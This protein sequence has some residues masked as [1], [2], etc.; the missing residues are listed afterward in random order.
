[1]NTATY[2]LVLLVSVVVLIFL[3]V[4]L[5]VNSFIALFVTSVALAI[6]FGG[7]PAEA[8]AA[9]N[10]AFG[11]TIG[12]IGMVVILGAVL[13]MGVQDSGAATAITN[14]FIR[15]FR[16]KRLELAPALTAFVMSI[17]VFGDVTQLLT[18]PI[19]ARIGK[20]K[21]LS[22]TLITPYTIVG[23]WLTHGVVPPSAGILAVCII[24]GADV[25]MAIFWS[26]LV[27]LC[28]LLITYAL[29][30]RF[31]RKTE[32]TEAKPEFVVGVQEADE[33]AETEALVIADEHPLN[34]LAAFLPLIVPAL[35]ITI[36]SLGNLLFPGN[37]SI[38]AVTS[39]V[40]DKTVAML[41]GII[42]L[43]VTCAARKKLLTESAIQSG[44]PISEKPTLLELGFGNWIERG[45]KVAA[46]VIMITAMG[47]AFST[48]LKSH[49]AVA[50]IANAVVASGIPMLLIPFAISAIMRA[51]CGSMATAT[52]T[53]AG[54]CAPIMGAMGLTPVAVALSIGM[55]SLL[56]G[57]VN[58]SGMWMCCEMFHLKPEQYLKYVT[59]ITTLAGIIGFVLLFILNGIGL[60]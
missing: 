3:N 5:K 42:I 20:R 23:V 4:K 2:L 16:G 15:L 34:P 57:H 13:A 52:M 58:D 26:I 1:M 38:V 49:P 30:I 29:T 44:V 39:L 12:N 40:G 31:M 7:T 55:G 53:A 51:A 17:S 11:S 21:R 27:C 37:E 48:I 60:L 24:L 35:L 22:M 54:I 36:G 43:L 46:M 59:P 56:F 50:E 33:D 9:V 32:F 8:L 19:A 45:I 14:F 25:G 41:I 18:A 10:N 47:G 6:L 28:T